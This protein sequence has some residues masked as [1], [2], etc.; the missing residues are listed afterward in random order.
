[1]ANN[2]S[3]IAEEFLF[4]KA[5][6]KDFEKIA[7]AVMQDDDDGFP[8]WMTEEDKSDLSE[9][10]GCFSLSDI[11]YGD[12]RLYIGEE[13]NADI[14]ATGTILSMVMRHHD[15]REVIPL[16]ASFTCSKLRPGEFGGA[17]CAVGPEGVRFLDENACSAKRARRKPGM[18]T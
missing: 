9:A 12:G 4:P 14:D 18:S 8:D 17:M 2:Y 7:N 10:M 3:A 11:S 5:A 1:M 16:H 15:I 13:E 6:A